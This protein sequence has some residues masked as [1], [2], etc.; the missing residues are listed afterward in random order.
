MKSGKRVFRDLY[1]NHWSDDTLAPLSLQK[2]EKIADGMLVENET[3][4]SALLGTTNTIKL[5]NQDILVLATNENIKI[6][7]QSG[8]FRHK[9][10]AIPY[11]NFR[12]ITLLQ[13]SRNQH[14]YYATLKYKMARFSHPRILR[15]EVFDPTSAFHFQEFV[16]SK[17]P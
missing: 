11:E 1:E 15:L 16:E 4:Y 5:Q 14:R 8:D 12:E 13:D 17:H 9:D 10:V 3:A 7:R 6:R 2:Y